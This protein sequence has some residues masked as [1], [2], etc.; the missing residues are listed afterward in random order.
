M[1]RYS[2]KNYQDQPTPIKT[3]NNIQLN[4]KSMIV[5]AILKIST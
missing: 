3:L 5:L 4:P 2:K 1:P